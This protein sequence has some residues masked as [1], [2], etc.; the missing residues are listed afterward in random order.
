MAT[1]S[2]AASVFRGSIMGMTIFAIVVLVCIGFA[3]RRR[4][5]PWARYLYFMRFA[6]LLWIFPLLL[7]WAD[8]TPARSLVS[9][10][11]TP[12]REGQYLCAAF[13]LFSASCVALIMARIVAING[14]ERFGDAC[15]NPLLRLLA[16]EGIRFE[17]VAPLLAQVNNIV[18]FWYFVANGKSEGVDAAGIWKGLGFGVALA[19]LFW[20]VVNALYYLTYR[21][22]PASRMVA[23]VGRP[24]ARTL[25]FPRSWFFL[26]SRAGDESFGDALELAGLPFSFNW[27]RNLFQVPGYRWAPAG[28]LYECHYFSLLAAFSFYLLFWVLWPMTAPVPVPSWSRVFTIL[29]LAFGLLLIV[30]V[31]AASSAPGTAKALRGWKILFTIAVLLFGL[32]VPL[33]YQYED[34]ERFPI[35]ALVLILVISC[36]WTVGAIAF[37]ADRYRVPVLTTILIALAIP[38]IFHWDGGREEHYLS[39]ATR[40]APANLPTPQE[41]L[42]AKLAGHPGEPLIVVTSTGGGIHAAAWTAAVLQ[43]LETTFVQDPQA[44]S[45][46]DHL[47]LLSTVSGGSA[48]LYTYLRELDAKANGGGW[49]WDRMAMAAQCSSLEAVGWGLVYYDIPKVV[50]PG[51]KAYSPG[52]D[53]LGELP[54]GKDRTW[55]L[56]KAFARNL[57]DPFCRLDS[58]SSIS[59][60]D[61]VKAQKANLPAEQEL[62]VADLNAIDRG[63]P[64]FTMNTTTVEN[65]ERFLLANYRIPDESIEPA[66]PNYKA[67]SFL[68]TFTKYAD[69]A[70]APDLPLATAAQMSATFPFVSSQARVPLAL[71]DSPE[72]VHFA[73]GGYYDNDGTAS[74]LE[75]LHYAIGAPPTTTSSATAPTPAANAEKRVTQQQEANTNGPVRIVLI[76]IR[77]SGGI[78]GSG[79]ETN[80]DHVEPNSIWNLFNQVTGPLLGFWQAGH[81]SITARDQSSLELLEHAYDGKIEVQA[82]VFADLWSADKARTD[83]L[84]WS[85]TPGQI[86]EVHNSATRREMQSLYTCAKQWFSAP[87]SAWQSPSSPSAAQL[88]AACAGH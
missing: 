12:S 66:G 85:L 2:L 23:A 26:S 79:P 34:A 9:G 59:L 3:L 22:A 50:L 15:P 49:D 80:P 31:L 67:R 16:D 48:G 73:D 88:T 69:S 87:Q 13:F 7:V 78:S 52:V 36:S 32:S 54:L 71:D 51:F 65:G 6:I 46:H 72:S 18:V 41:V 55:A 17:W 82:I 27:V 14:E 57:D 47:L 77:N 21:P 44:G 64:A 38:R 56:R 10:I 39:T 30:L 81:E 19:L 60:D 43:Q 83:P 76:E 25:L 45:F 62:T 33:L 63:F 70:A 61:L 28:N 84:N 37:F 1:A 20:Y 29:Y 53:D 11:V 74:A 35:L 42:D 24:S 86:A 8:T 5:A 75:F 68:A 40:P 58:T 4:L